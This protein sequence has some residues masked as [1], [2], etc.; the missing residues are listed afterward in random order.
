MSTDA[1]RARTDERNDE[2]KPWSP[3][4]WPFFFL[5]LFLLSLLVSRLTMGTR[6]RQSSEEWRL[7]EF[8][9][10]N[11]WTVKKWVWGRL[12]EVRLVFLKG[13][14]TPIAPTHC[15]SGRGGEQTDFLKFTLPPSTFFPPYFWKFR[16]KQ[17]G[18]QAK[19]RGFYSLHRVFGSRMVPYWH[20]WMI[21]L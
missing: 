10:E 6:V 14:M 9:S 7:Y 1:S 8:K 15:P 18:L 13:R 5:F 3:F 11:K 20:A 19:S 21:L 2:G 16:C 12:R 4:S 17:N